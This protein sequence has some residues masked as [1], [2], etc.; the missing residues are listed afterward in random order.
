[1]KKTLFAI[2]F[3]GLI[4]IATAQN[5]IMGLRGN[6][7]GK[8]VNITEFGALVGKVSYETANYYCPNC[9]YTTNSKMAY[10]VSPY[11]TQRTVANRLNISFQTFNGF[12]IKPK[13]AVGLVVGA[14]RYTSAL[15]MPIAVGVRQTLLQKKE[16]GSSIFA[17]FDAGYAT[18]WLQEDA[19]NYK[20]RGGI[21]FN[22]AIGYRLPMKNGSA[23]I[24]NFGY[25]FQEAKVDKNI[26]GY[27]IERYEKRTYNRMT[28][29]FGIQF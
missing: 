13:T 1:M 27:S 10:S 11:P 16:G 20:T 3:L 9:Y 5:K 22:P 14:D 21:M 19:S 18:T 6:L 26:E 8:F 23:W 24:L 7:K 28:V 15:L 12:H 29:R 17:A 2:F 25:K 4:E